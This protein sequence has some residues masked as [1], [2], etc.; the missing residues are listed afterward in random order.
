M[1]F[2]S[3]AFILGFLPVALIGFFVLGRLDLK[4]SAILWLGLVSLVFYAAWDIYNVPLLLISIAVNFTIGRR[5]ARRPSKTLLLIGITLNLGALFYFKYSG[6]TAAS[7]A[8]L[9]GWDLPNL[10]IVL[11]LAISFY[12]FQQIAYLCDTYD[13]LTDDTSAPNYFAFITFFPHLIAGPITHHK[14]LIPQ[15]QEPA[16]FRPQR[17]MISVGLTMF[18][19]GLFKKVILADN[20]AIYANQ[21]F[22]AAAQGQILT[23]TQSWAGAISYTLQIYFDF[24]GY[25]DMALG[26]G[27]LFGI[28][29]P[30]NFDSPLKAS[31]IIDYWSRWHITLTR[32]VTA[33]IYNP[34]VLRLTRHRLAQGK[35]MP[36]RGRMD[37]E[38][39]VV[40]V[41]A[42]TMTA[43][44]IIGIWH[45]AGWQFAAFGLIHGI[46]L[47]INHGWRTVALRMKRD[48]AQTGRAF[49]VPSILL[50]MTCV[51]IALVFFRSH[52]VAEAV[53][54]VKQMFGQSGVL[55]EDSYLFTK[56]QTLF[57]AVLL[58]IVWLCPNTQEW[59]RLFP[60][61]I[62][63]VRRSAW[64]ERHNMLL[65]AT[66]WRPSPRFAVI[67]GVIG[68][69][70]LA[71]AF[72]S[73]PAEFIYFNF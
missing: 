41:A 16:T 8:Q 5:L 71:Q 46:Y 50:T 20:I 58:T 61:G 48:G 65:S 33:Y 27:L 56:R 55:Y 70:A 3:A 60:T 12:T 19:I 25:S 51:V 2:N 52:N 64:F 69:F 7:V 66:S 4:R 30:F 62:G 53:H 63:S 45:G 10:N 43:M 6:F 73:A 68:F 40:L 11:P 34:I 21:V 24:S 9:F 42:P 57:L 32:F 54:L 31:S 35:S 17:T 39:F 28:R 59:L 14:E 67:V 26:L 15:F 38:T 13:G 1:L 29:L 23:V 37:G 36:K 22:D 47:A 18:L 72:S 44:L 49:A